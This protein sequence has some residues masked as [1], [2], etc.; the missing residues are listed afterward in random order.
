MLAR[1]AK[2]PGEA[3]LI[4]DASAATLRIAATHALSF[5]F[6]P[7]WLRDLGSA[8][9]AGQVQI[10]SDVLQ[11][12]EA[13]MQQRKV[14]FVLSHAHEK[15][16]GA[17]DA[18]D[19]RCAQVGSDVL[20]PV[21]RPDAHGR[22]LH[23]LEAAGGATLPALLYSEESGLGRILRAV[24]GRRLEQLP[25]HAAFTAHAASVLRTM[26]LDGR[27]LSWLPR[28]LVGDDLERGR[29]VAAADDD[30]NVP[31]AIRLYRAG[32]PMGKAAEAFWRCAT[33]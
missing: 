20:V 32:T 6:L 11:G 12:C 21:S 31:V 30:W 14:Q 15:A 23:G 18:E 7:Q 5:T 3:R 4:E 22:P 9:T 33:T 29:L 10:M 13:L 17:L 28:T 26:A 25:L 16:I 19:Y 27:G 8:S 1:V 2:L 24:L